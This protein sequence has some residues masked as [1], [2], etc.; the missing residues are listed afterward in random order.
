MVIAKIAGT[1]S[2][3][4]ITSATSTMTSAMKRG[5]M[6]QVILPVFGLTSFTKKRSP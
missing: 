5:V 2:T 4:K 6:N 1:E 3:A